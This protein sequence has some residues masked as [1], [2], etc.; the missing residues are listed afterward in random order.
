LVEA[1]A[2]FR[3]ALAIKPDF[4]QAHNNL[5]NSLRDRGRLEEAER[6]YRRALKIKPDYA[7]AHNN[8]G[9][10]LNGLGRLE[11]AEGSFRRAL[12]IKPDYAEAH[13]NLGNALKDL[14]PLD[15]A[16]ASYRRALAIKP[17]YAEALSNLGNALLDLG[18]LDEAE[19]C[20][21]RALE[22][23]PYFH[24]AHSNFSLLLLSIGSFAEAWPHHEFRSSL[25]KLKPIAFTPNLTCLQWGGENLS[26]KSLV[27]WPEQGFGDLIQFVRYSPLLKG[28]GLSRLTLVCP[29]T[30][31]ALFEKVAGVD[32]V[33]T[34]P[35]VLPPHS[36][37]AFYLS[38]PLHF[39][40]TI[41]TIPSSIP[42]LHPSPSL[43]ARW[44]GRLPICGIRVGLAW[45]GNS[46][47]KNDRHRSLEHLCLLA[48]IWSVP[49]VS[50]VSLQKGEG[51]EEARYSPPDRPILDLSKD[52]EDFSD[53]A[54]IVAQLDLVICVDTAVAHLAGAMGKPCW[55]LLPA[56]GCDWRWLRERDDSPWYPGVLRLFRQTR[57]GGWEKTISEVTDAL[58][59]LA[60]TPVTS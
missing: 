44:Q 35:T 1:E 32:S 28:L 60:A 57:E 56:L 36:Y 51:E 4:A 40:T 5:G 27:V 24:D 22:I 16:E 37:G 33:I 43:L 49:G 25:K 41:D 42:Y 31:R 59:M 39:Q 17:D 3:W 19:A 26:G 12:E 58:S 47:H 20:F 30:L 34:D 45:K 23:K 52:I 54:A 14:G 21:R 53:T 7:E 10:A 6:S 48:P 8:L 55:V 13:N 29:S 15:E 50:F 18:R 38:L 46:L 9:T 11:E 2:R